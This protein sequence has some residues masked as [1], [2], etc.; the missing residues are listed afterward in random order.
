MKLLYFI[1]VFFFLSFYS[2]F[3]Q[4]F[5]H[6]GSILSYEDLSRIKLHIDAGDEP[7][8]VLWNELQLSSMADCNGRP[9]KPVSDIASSDGARHRSDPDGMQAFINAVEWHITG[10]RKYADCAVRLLSA[11]GNTVTSADGELFQYPCRTQM[12]A[13][14]MLRYP[15]GRFYEGWSSKDRDMFLKK[16]RDIYYPACKKFCLMPATTPSWYAG[17]VT[18]IIIAG[19]LLDDEEI[20]NE[21][22][23]FF[24]NPDGTGSVYGVIADKNGQVSEMGR[25]NVHAM[26]GLWDLALSALI[27]YNQ[28]DDLFAE[29][30][31]RLMRGVDYWCRYN[32][33]YTDTP[34][35]PLNTG[36]GGH[37]YYISTHNNGFR[38]RPDGTVFESVYHHYKERKSINDNQMPYLSK[39][40]RLARPEPAGLGSGTLFYT[41]N[42]ESSPYSSENPDKAVGFDAESAL[43]YIL[44][45]WNMPLKNDARGFELYRSSDG[46]DFKRIALKD[47]YTG[48]MYVDNDVA[49]GT[50]YYYKMRFINYKGYSEWSD[51]VSATADKG[52]DLPDGW[53]V[54]NV[55]ASGGYGKYSPVQNGTFAVLGAGYGLGEPGDSYTFV[56]KTLTGDGSVVVRLTS[57]E[58]AFKYVG[59]AMR[60]SLSPDSPEA[61]MT[62][63]GAGWRY[64]RMAV[65]EDAGSNLYWKEG[66]IF[67]YA[68]AWF[69]LERK[70]NFV[71]AYQSRNGVDWFKVDGKEIKSLNKT[72]YVGM[73]SA[74]GSDKLYQAVFDNVSVLKSSS[75]SKT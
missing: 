10:E 4:R 63:G 62:L 1:V 18:G 74:S 24:R 31:N 23:D 66:D 70:G 37:F 15:D 42:A 55:S 49:V 39:F 17:A 48:C 8:T 16:V 35:E 2:S 34:W 59:I 56:Y 45:K 20:Y 44:L 5:K 21:G 64:G 53:L 51:V 19:V 52:S 29:D 32:L 71:A 26:L 73:F 12:I 14:E 41:I 72:L 54:A 47:Y 11:W 36:W 40:V 30:D 61:T 43:E 22:L 6:P 38:L 58:E 68:P 33:G 28:G 75:S 69:K 3:G 25:D 9:R 7:W 27:A 60:N 13:A 57:T 65:R 46:T 67:T 50:K